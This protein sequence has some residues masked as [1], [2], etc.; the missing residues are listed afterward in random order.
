[1]PP[2]RLVFLAALWGCNETV[3]AP[4]DSTVGR[5]TM[6]H[7]AAFSGGQVDL[8]SASFR[9]LQL[10]PQRAADGFFS[11]RNRWDNFV[12]TFGDDTADVWR[13]NDTTLTVRVPVLLAGVYSPT[14]SIDGDERPPLPSITLGG[15]ADEPWLVP[16]ERVT[17][18]GGGKAIGY[19][20]HQHSVV[21]IDLNKQSHS[22]IPTLDF[23]VP[24]RGGMFVPGYSY[25]PNQVVIDVRDTAEAP[26]GWR[27]FPGL[28][29]ATPADCFSRRG[30]YFAVSQ[31]APDKCVGMWD[32]DGRPTIYINGSD[33]TATPIAEP[34][35]ALSYGRLVTARNG[36]WTVPITRE[37]NAAYCGGM[38]RWPI[39]DDSPDVAYTI[40]RYS[41]V[42]GAEFTANGDTLFLVGQPALHNDSL[43]VLEALDPSSGEVLVSRNI[44]AARLTAVMIDPIFPLL[45]VSGRD[46][47]FRQTLQVFDRT[48]LRPI[49]KMVSP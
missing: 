47:Q 35:C 43:W 20:T 22:T 23:V 40:D 24:E 12:L 32:L 10:S 38:E 25:P 45:W 26:K 29:P 21:V 14:L 15:A 17:P 28:R 4:V 19:G 44:G 13:T 2:L 48:N 3:Q 1:M 34:N 9:D 33:D 30:W 36:K 39:I 46:F 5:I 42:P 27:I 37:Q 49:G 18:I 11:L 8:I 41:Q 7:S 6:A 16:T 31:L